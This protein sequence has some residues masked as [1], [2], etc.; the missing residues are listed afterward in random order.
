[1]RVLL[2]N[3]LR[4]GS[5]P[6]DINEL[7]GGPIA[8][9]RKWFDEWAGIEASAL[10]DTVVE[11]LR[12]DVYRGMAGESPDTMYVK[13]H[14]AWDVRTGVNRFSPQMLPPEWFTSYATLWVL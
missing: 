9:V 6:A 14:D 1:M 4:N 12:P 8:S 10:S 11:R 7:D 2:T 13:V 3:Y 5:T